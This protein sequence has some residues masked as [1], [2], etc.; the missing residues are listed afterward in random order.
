VS[1]VA[2]Y[3]GS[4]TE[5]D[6]RRSYAGMPEDLRNPEYGAEEEEDALDWLAGLR[7]FFA[8]AASAHDHVVFSVRL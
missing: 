1:E 2:A 3:L 7:E 4:L 5:D 8:V 6:F